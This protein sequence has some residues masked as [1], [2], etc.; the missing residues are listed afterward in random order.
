MS[1]VKLTGFSDDSCTALS[2]DG[3]QHR[4]AGEG[5]SLALISSRKLADVLTLASTIEGLFQ[6]A[7]IDAVEEELASRNRHIHSISGTAH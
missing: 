7:F 2:A 6:D 1:M 3:P 5:T 4:E